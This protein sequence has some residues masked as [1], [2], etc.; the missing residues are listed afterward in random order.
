MKLAANPKLQCDNGHVYE[1]KNALWVEPVPLPSHYDS[2]HKVLEFDD[3]GCPICPPPELTY[4]GLTV[5]T[6]ADF[7]DEAQGL[8]IGCGLREVAARKKAAA[9]AVIALLNAVDNSL[10]VDTDH[11]LSR[12]SLSSLAHFAVRRGEET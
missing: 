4:C 11:V 6:V 3:P 7:L 2:S 1:A 9:R 8:A 5:D 12:E 10:D